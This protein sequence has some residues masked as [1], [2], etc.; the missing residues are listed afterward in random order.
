MAN[1]GPHLVRPVVVSLPFVTS[2]CL[3][4]P[5]VI[6]M[7]MRRTAMICVWLHFARNREN[8]SNV[9]I[10]NLDN[11]SVTEAGLLRVRLAE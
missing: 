8:A 3:L 5:A 6:V 4:G 9:E 10:R 7:R 11:D 1:F 2:R